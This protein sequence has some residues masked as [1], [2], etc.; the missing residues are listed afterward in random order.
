MNNKLSKK[1][2]LSDTKTIDQLF[3]LGKA[4]SCFP[5]RL[6]FLDNTAVDSFKIGFSVPKRNIKL[7]SKRNRI[8]RKIKEVFRVEQHRFL[9]ED[10]KGCGFLIY[11]SKNEADENKIEKAVQI[12]LK[13]WKSERAIS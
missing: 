13:K 12:L 9:H 10:F 5:L 3:S 11:T 2:I 7:A 1:N 6:V 4:L 8:K